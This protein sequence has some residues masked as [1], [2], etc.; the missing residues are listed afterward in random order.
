MWYAYSKEEV[1]QWWQE[2][3]RESST[4]IYQQLMRLT[5]YIYNSPC[6]FKSKTEYWMHISSS[7]D[8]DW[9]GIE[10]FFCL[11][12]FLFCSMGSFFSKIPSFYNTC[13]IAVWGVGYLAFLSLEPHIYFEFCLIFLLKP[14]H[15][16]MP[17][18]LIQIKRLFPTPVSL[19]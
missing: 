1:K 12:L 11:F 5:N 3:Q 13:K 15:N 14:F 4:Y 8:P 6:V 9:S 7:E 19:N 2:L 17:D 10:R 18:V 16:V